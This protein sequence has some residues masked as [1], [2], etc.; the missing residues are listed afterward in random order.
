MRLRMPG[1]TQSLVEADGAIERCS[2]GR[3][4]HSGKHAKLMPMCIDVLF[5]DLP[6]DSC[7]QRRVSSDDVRPRVM[8]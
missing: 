1:N 8:P 7:V 4:D 5:L 6:L 3:H 2:H